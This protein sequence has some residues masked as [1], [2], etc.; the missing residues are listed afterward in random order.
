MA[1]TKDDLPYTPYRIES[2]CRVNRVGPRVDDVVSFFSSR[3]N[4][5]SP[6]P[7]HAGERVSPPPPPLVPGGKH[8]QS[9]AGDGVGGDPI[10]TRGWHSRYNIVLC[11]VG[12][13]TLILIWRNR[14][15]VTLHSANYPLQKGCAVF[16]TFCIRFEANLSDYGSNL[17]YICMFRYILKDHLFA[18]FA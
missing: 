7:S 2:L 12:T 14:V 5:D 17:P 18:S 3:P 1:S 10:P 15:F 13:L 6:I 11:G 4:W 16:A 9:L 8:M